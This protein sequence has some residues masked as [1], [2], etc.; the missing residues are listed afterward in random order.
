M[1]KTAMTIKPRIIR[2]LQENW[3][4][5]P[6]L[7][8][9]LSSSMTATTNKDNRH[10]WPENNRW[11]KQKMKSR[12]ERENETNK[13]RTTSG[14]KQQEWSQRNTAKRRRRKKMRAKTKEEHWQEDN[15]QAV[16]GG[17]C[18][19]ARN[20]SPHQC[21]ISLLRYRPICLF[22]RH[23]IANPTQH[24]TSEHENQKRKIKGKRNRK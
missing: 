4:K 15:R 17:I 22:L 18:I 19:L 5:Q 10:V 24:I 11:E 8:G 9:R 12:K 6:R 3:K 21:R 13:E 2:K 16:E 23:P 7:Y 20:A 1:K 14:S